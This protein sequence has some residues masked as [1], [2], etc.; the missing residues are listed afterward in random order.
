MDVTGETVKIKTRN[1]Q[2]SFKKPHIII[3]DIIIFNPLIVYKKIIKK[4]WTK[5]CQVHTNQPVSI[6]TKNIRFLTRPF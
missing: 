3:E 2:M 1:G 4:I 5:K 6:P